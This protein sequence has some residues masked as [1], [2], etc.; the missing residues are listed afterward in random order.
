[1]NCVT[2]CVQMLRLEFSGSAAAIDPAMSSKAS[3]WKRETVRVMVFLLRDSSVEFLQLVLRECRREREVVS[4]TQDVFL[5]LPAQ[6]VAQE[7]AGLG[8]GL[9]PIARPRVSGEVDVR[10]AGERIGT[11]GDAL[12]RQRD[13]RAAGLLGEREGFHA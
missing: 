10:A 11:V 6:H 8:I 9:R 2:F 7:F 3:A 5:S 12:R 1:M 13:E 4:F